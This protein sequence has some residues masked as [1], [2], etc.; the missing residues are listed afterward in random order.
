MY[1]L[2]AFPPPVK[3]KISSCSGYLEHLQNVMH[4]KKNYIFLGVSYWFVFVNIQI[5]SP[6]REFES[7]LTRKTTT[8]VQMLDGL[9]NRPFLSDLLESEV[10]LLITIISLSINLP[11][12]FMI[13]Q[14][15]I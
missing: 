6:L 11:I 14:F 7:V 15:I 9:N 4:K 5:N 10:G 3:N 2:M 1:V 8:S 13:I 12:T